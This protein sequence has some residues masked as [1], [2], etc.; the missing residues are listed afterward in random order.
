MDSSDPPSGKIIKKR[1]AASEASE[2]TSTV[3]LLMLSRQVI[4][5]AAGLIFIEFSQTSLL[6]NVYLHTSGPD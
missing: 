1:H 3:D 5:D 4:G 6:R 2:S